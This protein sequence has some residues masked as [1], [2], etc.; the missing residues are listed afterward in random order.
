MNENTA[1]NLSLIYKGKKGSNGEIP[2]EDMVDSLDG[3]KNLY[4]EIIRI[5][6]LNKGEK[7]HTLYVKKVSSGSIEIDFIVKEITN[8]QETLLNISSGIPSLIIKTLFDYIKFKF[9]TKNERYNISPTV[10]GDHNNVIII[11]NLREE[12]GFPKNTIELDQ[13]GLSKKAM[14]R[15]VAP[16]SDGVEELE[17]KSNYQK[18]NE[19]EKISITGQDKEYFTYKKNDDLTKSEESKTINGFWDRL[20]KSSNSG[21]IL[22]GEN[23][24]RIKLV[25]NN[26]EGYYHMFSNNDKKTLFKFRGILIIYASTKIYNSKN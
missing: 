11:N 5:T 25:M 9:F 8:N 2:V 15:I 26:P 23:K 20:T 7:N 3:I 12:K 19:Y 1:I 17:I 6:D 18:K 13:K 24:I 21:I 14:D 10:R 22:S 4:Q 16:I